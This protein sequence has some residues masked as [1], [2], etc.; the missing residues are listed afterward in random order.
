MN[1][2][3]IGSGISGNLTARLLASRHRVKLFEAASYAG[4]H[5][6]SVDVAIS[7]QPVTVDTGFMVFNERTYPNFCRML[8]L[9]NVKSQPSDMSFSVRCDATSLEYNGS[10]VNTL[11]AQRTN[12]LRPW[13]YGLVRGILQF[14]QVG[15]AYAKQLD[16]S[17]ESITLGEFLDEH[18]VSDKVRQYYLVP[19]LAAIWSA[20]PEAIEQ[21]PA[22]FI[23]GFMHNHGLM[24]LADR[25]RWRT[26]VG[27]AKN[28]VA[29]LLEPIKEQVRLSTPV[30]RVTRHESGV[31]VHA[32][33]QPAEEFDQVVFA[34]HADQTLAMLSDATLAEQ[35]ILSALPYQPNT[36]ILHGDTTVMPTRPRAWASWNYRI[37]KTKNH[38]PAAASVTYDLNRLQN[39]P[40]NE[41]VFVTLNPVTDIDEKKIHE[42][43]Q[44]DHPAYTLESVQAQQRWREINGQQRTWFCGA[45]WG[46]GF[47]E[48]GV[49]SALR[50]AAEFGVTLDE[51]RKPVVDQTNCEQ[52][53]AAAAN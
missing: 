9:L 46:Y 26:I 23:L 30:E 44:Y 6:N 27:G 4:G 25:P 42:T 13:F 16:Q 36:A 43:F 5:T 38:Q 2:A 40:T 22:R 7:R 31:T 8:D 20:A 35:Q 17:D 18:R 24:Q 48:D 33:N 11:F 47:H 12:L 3:I 34:T 51:L 10:S 52:R 37:P 32:K 39:L 19:M 50:V 29:K 53:V 41:P 1:I 21:L 49:N 15:E 28:Y 45:Y 14:N